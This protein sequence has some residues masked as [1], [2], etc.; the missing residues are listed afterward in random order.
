[1]QKVNLGRSIRPISTGVDLYGVAAIAAA[2]LVSIAVM[3]QNYLALAAV[4]A[5]A[6]A[7]LFPV[8]V[9][10]GMFAVLVPFD[11][12]LV[13]GNSGVTVTWVAGGF[14]ATTLLIYG[15]VRGRFR[16]STRTGLY[17]GLFVLWAATSVVWALDPATGLKRL[18]TVAALFAVYI[19]AASFR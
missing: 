7:I 4:T 11:Q 12:V 2:I 18:P 10:L 9:S 1:E 5:L 3:R 6:F 16:S 8:E 17:W 15:L 13:L 19:V 14:A